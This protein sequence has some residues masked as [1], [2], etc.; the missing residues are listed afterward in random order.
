M[1]FRA[2]NTGIS[3][4]RAVEAASGFCAANEPLPLAAHSKTP[5]RETNCPS[6]DRHLLFI[7]VI[8]Q[9]GELFITIITRRK[10]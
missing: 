4:H 6:P 9:G 7:T 10:S 3:S 5:V 2:Q 8:Q 1:N